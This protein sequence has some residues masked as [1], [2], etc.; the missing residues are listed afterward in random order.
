MEYKVHSFTGIPYGGISNE[1]KRKAQP[2]TK[3]KEVRN[4]RAKKSFSDF[5]HAQH[6]IPFSWVTGLGSRL[7][8]VIVEHLLDRT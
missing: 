7:W 5:E 4:D 8:D 1:S 2:P 6:G 3:K